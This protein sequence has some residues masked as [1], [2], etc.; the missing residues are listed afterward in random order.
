M[1]GSRN[2]EEILGFL[3]KLGSRLQGPKCIMR[4]LTTRTMNTFLWVMKTPGHVKDL[5]GLIQFVR[6]TKGV[7]LKMKFSEEKPWEVEAYSNSDYAG[8]KEYR[9][10]VTGMVIFISGVPFS[11]KSKGQPTV[12]LSSTESEYVALCETVREVKFNS[13]VLELLQIEYKKPIRVHVD[14][15]G[16]IFLSENRNSGKRDQAHR[17]KV[18][19]HQRTN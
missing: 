16:G 4:S 15:M 17:H 7:S 10:S 3:E 12:T 9:K 1:G 13:Q 6:N 5:K 14:N 18:P 19:L 11:W 8:D 2:L